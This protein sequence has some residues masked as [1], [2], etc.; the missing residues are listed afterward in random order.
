MLIILGGVR[1]EGEKSSCG[2]SKYRKDKWVLGE[3]L[4]HKKVCGNVC[5]GGA[6]GL[7]SSS[8]PRHSPRHGFG[9]FTLDLSPEGR[10]TLPSK[11]GIDGS[12]ISQNS[13]AP[14]LP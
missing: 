8:R 11:D 1:E 12:L 14:G 5:L 4:R 13:I 9:R 2:K 3:Q 10:N 6:S 7:S